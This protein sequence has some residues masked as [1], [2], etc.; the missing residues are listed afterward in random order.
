MVGTIFH[1]DPPPDDF[2]ER[3]GGLLSLRPEAY[4][5]ASTDMHA[6]QLDIGEIQARYSELDLPIGVLY[7]DE[8]AVLQFDRHTSALTDILPDIH[9]EIIDGAGHM[10][11]VVHAERTLDFVRHMAGSLA[12]KTARTQSETA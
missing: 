11:L 4:Y 1:P 7:G 3:G 5:A 2:R 10:P 12:E 8:D 6:V 9:V